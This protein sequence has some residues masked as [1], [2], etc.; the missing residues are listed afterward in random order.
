MAD[1]DEFD[2]SN[3]FFAS[4]RV[5]DREINKAISDVLILLANRAKD[6]SVKALAGMTTELSNG[7][8]IIARDANNLLRI[9]EIYEQGLEKDEVLKMLKAITSSSFDMTYQQA[10]DK[11]A[12][13]DKKAKKFG[14]A[15]DKALGTDENDDDGDDDDDI[16]PFDGLKPD[17]GDDDDKNRGGMGPI[18]FD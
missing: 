10:L 14:K 7:L 2:I 16:D 5:K 1:D 17:D 4:N 15:I 3:D 18:T 9:K 12:L 6:Y 11:I 8:N 13:D